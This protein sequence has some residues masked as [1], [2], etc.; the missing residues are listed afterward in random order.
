MP[1]H[2]SRI[3]VTGGNGILANALAPYFPLGTFLGRDD[4]DVT[5]ASSVRAAFNDV[6]PELVIHCAAVTA[7]NAEPFAYVMGNVLGTIHVV[8]AA[9]K[10]GARVVYPSTDYLGARLESDPVRPVNAYAASKY[11]GEFIV[12]SGTPGLVVRGSW[13][14]RP[15]YTHAATDAFCTRVKVDTAAYWMASL[16]VSSL[17][18]TIN[19]GGERRSL[20]EIALEA[21]ERVVPVSRHQVRCGYEI[22]ADSSLDTTKLTRFLAA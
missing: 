6:K 16:A 22:P 8:A 9:K 18:G 13:Y 11:C 2:V 14:S 17:T 21:N 19:I 12:G 3:L 1:S 15:A 4:C 20:Y 5:N 7:H 10:L